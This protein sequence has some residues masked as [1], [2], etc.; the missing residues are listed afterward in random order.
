MR[1]ALVGCSVV[2]LRAAGATFAAL[3]ARQRLSAVPGVLTR[4]NVNARADSHAFG[5]AQLTR[6]VTGVD[7]F[8][9]WVPSAPFAPTTT[10]G[11]GSL[12]AAV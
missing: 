7:L 4:L 6:V 3:H 11:R 5:G 9:R 10:C 2:S 8:E 1:R 12:R